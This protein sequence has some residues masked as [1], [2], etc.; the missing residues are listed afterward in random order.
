MMMLSQLR[1]IIGV[2]CC[3]WLCLR[4]DYEWIWN[5]FTV[6]TVGYAKELL[7]VAKARTSSNPFAW[8]ALII[9]VKYLRG[10]K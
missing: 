3:H 9:A 2:G 4:T 10:V 5:E 7:R 1:I 6:N 8:Q